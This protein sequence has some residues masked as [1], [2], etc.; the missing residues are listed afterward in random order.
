M[1]G[2]IKIDGIYVDERIL[3]AKFCC[4]YE[5]CKGA[6]CSQPLPGVELN[7]GALSAYD[8]AEILYHRRALSTLCED[9][10]KQVA[11]E[12]PVSKDGGVFYTT[13]R[14]DKCVF[15]NTQKGTCVLKIAKEK[16]IA[17]IDIPLSCQLY[18]ILWVE[19]PTYEAL[20]L[21]DLYDA[22]YCIYAYEKGKREGIFLIDF[23]KDA[24]IRAFGKSFF[25]K[26]KEKQKT[27]L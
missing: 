11:I 10:D 14:N 2:N 18:P 26:L 21:G 13:L 17:D 8:A 23:L 27:L 16:H 6:C 25:Y 24:I 9:A 7:G 3:T 15:C 5:K 12:H 4:D 22:E 1:S 20:K 19:Y